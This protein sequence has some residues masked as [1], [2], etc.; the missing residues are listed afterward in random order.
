[1]KEW[2]LVCEKHN[3]RYY[4]YDGLLTKFPN[5]YFDLETERKERKFKDGIEILGDDNKIVCISDANTHTERLVFIGAKVINTETNI[6]NY[7]IWS[8][9]E[10]D[11]KMT[12]LT[13]G[14]DKNSVYPDEVYLRHLRMLNR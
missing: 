6:T 7:T 14:G 8:M 2:K 1:M 3:K 10:I 4:E 13:T 11:G 9:F 12:F 5:K